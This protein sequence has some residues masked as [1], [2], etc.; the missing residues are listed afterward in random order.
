MNLLGPPGSHVVP[1]SDHF[2]LP[3]LI[4]RHVPKAGSSTVT[5]LLDDLWR[6]VVDV[7]SDCPKSNVHK[8]LNHSHP[9]VLKLRRERAVELVVVREPLDRFASG[10]YYR[11]RH[12][13][14]NNESKLERLAAYVS[15]LPDGEN[16]VHLFPQTWFFC[17]CE[18][19]KK[20]R[21]ADRDCVAHIRYVI[22]LE[23]LFQD[24]KP[25][26][27]D[28]LFKDAPLEIKSKVLTAISDGA[29][30][31]RGN[32]G[33]VRNTTTVPGGVVDRRAFDDRLG[34]QGA[35]KLPNITIPLCRY[36]YSDYVALQSFYTLPG[37]CQRHATWLP[38]VLNHNNNIEL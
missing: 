17:T 9:L 13:R 28:V 35:A 34:V 25:F 15:E 5:H 33:K 20:K 31:F 3:S 8:V 29:A 21:T 14:S 38:G 12:R 11:N 24:W 26:L 18:P 7:C 22:K 32:V 6:K 2:P 37:P 16:D 36:L 19:R 1:L 4:V 30:A 23:N 10:Y 27:R